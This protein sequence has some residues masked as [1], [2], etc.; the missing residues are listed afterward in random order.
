MLV[1]SNSIS[2][3]I[4]LEFC[5]VSSVVDSMERFLMNFSI[6]TWCTGD[7][8]FNSLSTPRKISAGSESKLMPYGA[9]LFFQQQVP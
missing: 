1:F 9:E 3:S 4:A 2:T 7:M 5:R 8:R 6:V